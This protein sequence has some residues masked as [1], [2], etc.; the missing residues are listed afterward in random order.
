M[1]ILIA[2]ALAAATTAL[3]AHTSTVEHRGQNLAV[4]YRPVVETKLRQAGMA[5][6]GRP[7]TQICNWKASV[8]VERKLQGAA[9][10]QRVGDVREISGSQA[11][12]CNL[13][14]DRIAQQVAARGDAVQA[15]VAAVAAAD[16]PVLLA[17]L[18]IAHGRAGH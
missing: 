5:P 9:H 13:Q 11:G 8:S 15:H 10:S 3:P 14:G 7:A 4:E 1:S 18:D 16:R 17:D 6:P 2:A 12:D